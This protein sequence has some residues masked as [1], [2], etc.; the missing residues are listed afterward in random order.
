MNK[1]S[2]SNYHKPV[3]RPVVSVVIP[4]FNGA[5]FLEET[6]ASIQKSTYRKFEILLI[7]DG[8]TD[9]SKA[10]CKKLQRQH[11]NVRF[12]DFPRNRGL[13]RVLNFALKKAKGEY[14][15]R[16][17][18]DDRMLPQRIE[19]QTIYL[20]R[21]TDLVAVGSSILL[22]NNEGFRRRLDFLKKDADIRKLWLMLSPFSDPAVTYRKK[23]ALLVGGYNQAFWPAD[24]VHLWFRLGRLGKLANIKQILVH[25]RWHDKAASVKY[26]RLDTIRTLKLHLWANEFVARAPWYVWLFWTCQFIAGIILTPQWNWAAYRSLKRLITTIQDAEVRRHPKWTHKKTIAKSVTIHPVKAILSGI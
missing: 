8:S 3:K 5:N 24:D 6:V 4:V 26:F 7:D 23:E 25:V 1:K 20:E 12:Y 18:Q 14:I 13:G 17:N 9:K 2:R 11:Q 16:I 21:H 19:K 10:I 22:F 15:C